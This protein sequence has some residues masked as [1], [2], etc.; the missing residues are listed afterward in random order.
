MTYVILALLVIVA[1]T[2][3]AGRRLEKVSATYPGLPIK[4]DD[5]RRQRL[6]HSEV[7]DQE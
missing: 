2:S 6:A 7:G 3:W 4:L 5:L 1:V